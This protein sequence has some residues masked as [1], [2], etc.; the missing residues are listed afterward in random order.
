MSVDLSLAAGLS[1]SYPVN[2]FLAVFLLISHDGA[3]NLGANVH[4]N[5][6]CFWRFAEK[7]VGMNGETISNLL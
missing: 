4:T 6:G 7:Q 2:H 5:V 3:V 1:V